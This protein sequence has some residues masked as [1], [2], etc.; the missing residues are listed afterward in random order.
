MNRNGMTTPFPKELTSPPAC[1]VVTER[2]MGGKYVRRRP[3]LTVRH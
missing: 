3:P 2:G 1:R